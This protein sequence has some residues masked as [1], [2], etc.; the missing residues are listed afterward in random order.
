MVMLG[1]PM[2]TFVHTE[3]LKLLNLSVNAVLLLE[4]MSIILKVSH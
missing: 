4:E 2:I 1:D 3:T